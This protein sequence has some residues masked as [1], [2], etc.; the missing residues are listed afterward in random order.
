MTKAGTLAA[1]IAA[2]AIVGGAAYYAST[3]QAPDR[4]AAPTVLAQ[5]SAPMPVPPAAPPTGLPAAPSVQAKAG[6]QEIYPDPVSVPGALNPDVT[7]ATITTTICQS[8]WTATVRPPVSYTNAIKAVLMADLHLAGTLQDYELDH[9]IPLEVGGAPRDRKNLWMEP[10][11]DLAHPMTKVEK[12]HAIIPL[13]PNS[14]EKDGVET[15]LKTEVCAGRMTLA[16]AQD[17][18]R[19]DWDAYY[20]AWKHIQ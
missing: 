10:Y 13:Q 17:T 1:S 11:G 15:H 12:A 7:Q 16:R 20:N 2:V 19:T 5:T 18:V 4:P 14:A 3:Q 9:F 8:G 6:P